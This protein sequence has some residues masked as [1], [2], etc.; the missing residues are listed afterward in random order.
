MSNFFI[1][2]MKMLGIKTVRTTAYHF[3]AI[4]KLNGTTVPWLLSCDITS[5]MT[6]HDEKSYSRSS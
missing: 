5:L 6:H 3:Q 2:V 1:A 4:S